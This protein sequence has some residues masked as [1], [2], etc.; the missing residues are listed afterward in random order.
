MSGKGES[1]FLD[2][3]GRIEDPRMDRQK[4]HKLLDIIGI[5]VCAAIAGVDGWA[6]V[7]LFGKSKETW[8][9]TF[10]ELENGIPSH[11]TF[12]RVFSLLSPDAFQQAFREWV[13]AIQGRVE[14]L[15]A[16]D[17]KTV[18]GSHDRAN[19][20][21]AIHIVSAWAVDSGISL[22]Q[23]K[24]NDKSNEITAIPELLRM[25]DLEGCV[26]SIDAMGCQRDIA[27]NILD[28]RG[29]Y[30]LA[31]KGNQETLAED[32]EQE[33]K[34]AQADGFAHMDHFYRDVV[35]KGH[36]RIERRQYWYTHD[37]QGLGTLERWPKLSGM[38]MC[39]ATR[40]NKGQTS[41]EDR[42][43]ITSCQ[44][45]D[46]VR[47]AD[48]VRNHWGIENGLHWVLDVAFLED[49]SRIRTGHG[50]ENM[51][52]IRKIAHNT[53]KKS[54][55]RKGGIK[56]KRLQAGWDNHYMEEILLAL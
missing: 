20:K 27:Q 33:F 44:H 34:H 22:G 51:A 41:V 24:V 15:V 8:L 37:V 18:R 46:V 55:S 17:G 52:A 12:G 54:T 1:V 56:A 4:K 43:F 7:E 42:Y 11:D 26:V 19:G 47:I 16:I 30:L 29:D 45:D 14:G 25:L 10:L 48:A 3:F 35:E 28:A 13:G 23:V 38:V 6:G 21:Q 50:P 40:T 2:C 36:G 9:R 32:V 49:Q 31:V 39:R 5:A 53:L